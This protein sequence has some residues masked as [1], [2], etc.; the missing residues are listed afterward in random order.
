MEKKENRSLR[1]FDLDGINF[2]RKRFYAN[3]FR[4]FQE[5]TTNIIKHSK[6]SMVTVFIT[7]IEDVFFMGIHDNGIG[8]PENQPVRSDAFGL[9]SIRE[10]VHSMKGKCCILSKEKYGTTIVVSIPLALKNNAGLKNEIDHCSVCSS[11][12]V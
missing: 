12:P 4:I 3:L 11:S 2:S 1:S 6:A 7:I 5:I 10:R 8:M 9:I